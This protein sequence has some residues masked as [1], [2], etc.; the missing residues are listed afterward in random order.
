[1]VHMCSFIIDRGFGKFAQDCEL[2]NEDYNFTTEFVVNMSGHF[3]NE[4]NQTDC[5]SDMLRKY[6][7]SSP[8][9]KLSPIKRAD[10]A[11]NSHDRHRVLI[12][13]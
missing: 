7:T 9:G 1:M 6:L 12:V 2:S 10:A 4:H 5:V 8:S 13:G 3:N 11:I